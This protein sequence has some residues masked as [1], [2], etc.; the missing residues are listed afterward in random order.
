MSWWRR[1]LRIVRA[2]IQAYLDAKKKEE[3]NR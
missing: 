1:V 2:V 3:A